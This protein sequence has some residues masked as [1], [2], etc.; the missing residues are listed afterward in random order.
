MSGAGNA[1]DAEGY[2]E[3]VTFLSTVLKVPEQVIQ[4]ALNVGGYSLVTTREW[5]GVTALAQTY[6]NRIGAQA[7]PTHTQD[8]STA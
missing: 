5:E 6:I 7:W 1:A 4:S 2:A 8:S 3:G